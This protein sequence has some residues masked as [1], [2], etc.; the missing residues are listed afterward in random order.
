LVPRGFDASTGR[1]RYDVNPRFADTRP[2]RTLTR[3]PFRIVIDFSVDL[4]VNYDV[5][6]LRRALEPVKVPGGGW[7]RRT[8]DSL[9]AFY[10]SRT[11]SVHKALLAE[12]DSLFLSASQI[13]QLRR[14]DSVYAARVRGLYVPLGQFLASRPGEPAKAEL[15]T[16]TATEKAYWKVF[17]EQP[18]V[19]GAIVT[20]SQ[21]Q[22]VPFILRM[23]EVPMKDRENSR[24]QFGHAVTFSDAKPATTPA[25]NA[26]VQ[27][28]NP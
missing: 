14:A 28:R 13:A 27:I 10:L 18:E 3:D 23:T 12:S 20:R 17:W 8:A 11:S 7:A 24:W 2:G 4:A 6:Q 9:A 19:A 15:D 22:F 21:L 1:Y 25:P 16:V 26:G 5:Q